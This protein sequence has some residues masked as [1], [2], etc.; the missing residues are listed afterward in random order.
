MLLC[1][2]FLNLL[3]S[4]LNPVHS[5]QLN[6]VSF[7]LVPLT[8]LLLDVLQASV[9]SCRRLF[10]VRFQLTHSAKVISCKLILFLVFVG[11]TPPQVSFDEDLSV[12]HVKS[13]V[14]H[15]GRILDFFPVVLVL[16]VTKS[17]I[18]EN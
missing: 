12:V 2:L 18:V 6:V 15:L 3:L 7:R 1:G 5:R 9:Q 4:C 8:R 11:Q 10:V 14:K 13:T 16:T 17:D